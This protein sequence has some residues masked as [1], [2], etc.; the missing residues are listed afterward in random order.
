MALDNNLGMTLQRLRPTRLEQAEV[1][2]DAAFDP[3]FS[4][5]VT[6]RGGSDR[7][8]GSTEGSLTVRQKSPLGTVVQ[9]GMTVREAPSLRDTMATTAQ[10]TVTQPL[11]EGAGRGVNLVG[12]RQARLSTA[13]SREEV[14]GVAL[15]LASQ[16][17]QAYLRAFLAE[18]KLSIF[19]ESLALAQ[20]QLDR[21]NALIDVGKLAGV[22]R[23]A[24][25]A[26][27]A[28]R[29]E[30]LVVAQGE[31]SQSRLLLVR[32][33]NTPDEVGW[34][35]AVTLMDTLPEPVAAGTVQDHLAASDGRPDLAQARLD[36]ARQA[37]QVV[38]TKNGLL[39][40]LDL[41]LTLGRS[42]TS[43]SFRELS[44]LLPSSN[45]SYAA[46][47]TLETDL[48]Q[49]ADKARYAQSVISREESS[50][51]VDNLRQRIEESVRT[52]Y[53]DAQ[54]AR[55]QIAATAATRKL[56]E[57]KAA[58]EQQKF[59]TGK[60]TSLLVAQAQRDLLTS[61]ISEVEVQVRYHQALRTLFETD[62]SLLERFGLQVDASTP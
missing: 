57:A 12:L 39:P 15:S 30:D 62:G 5:G 50:L 10:G 55:E 60:S 42:G 52:A 29:H 1:V 3:S 7:G 24:A 19:R 33:L 46:G 34:D 48:R 17:Q 27:L 9:L 38:Q 40:K 6:R 36:L 44:D 49:R 37:L 8:E 22:E 2:Q 13:A 23:A 31:L 26:E 35:N 43:S 16:V 56:Q 25:E 58:A 4:A 45:A 28:R 20:R 51:S 53:L 14:R 47:L 32:L 18:K 59:D 21:T 61:Q 11:L 41:F 54:V